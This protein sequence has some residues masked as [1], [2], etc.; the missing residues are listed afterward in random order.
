MEK[1]TF[2]TA[3]F[4]IGRENYSAVP[5]SNQKYYDYFKFWAGMQNYLIVYTDKESEK[6]I[7][8]IRSEYNLSHRT[9]VIVVDD[10]RD[11]DPEIITRLNIIEHDAFFRAFRMKADATSNTALYNYVMY[12][13]SWFLNDAVEK[14]LVK[15][16]VAWIDFGFNHGGKV[17]LNS[18]ELNFAAVT[19]PIDKIQVYF[20]DEFDQRPIMQL[21]QCLEDCIL[22]P[23]IMMP[24]DLAKEFYLENRK[25]IIA[26]TDLGLMDDD[27]LIMMLSVR[28]RPEIFD[29]NQSD[30]FL[31]L[32]DLGGEHLT[33]K[34][35]RSKSALKN[36]LVYHYIKYMDLKLK[37]SYLYRFGKFLLKEK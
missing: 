24:K 4:D 23:F 18:K 26:L 12:L 22:G 17:F 8:E 1:I 35:A 14:D 15:K 29:L 6:Q 33:V 13:K 31:P 28:R 36:Y 9:K 5:R 21:V 27:Q 7:N 3:F 19:K 32:K 10:I 34:K 37:I 16:N 11:I 2:V 20:Q 25:S 30:W